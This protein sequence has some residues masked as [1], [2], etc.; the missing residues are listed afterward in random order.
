MEEA[1][2]AVLRRAGMPGADAFKNPDY[3]PDIPFLIRSTEWCRKGGRIAMTL[4]ARL[5]LKNKPIPVA[6]R[7]T[8]FRMMDIAGI[9]SGV[10]L[11]KTEVWPGTDQPYILLFA[12]NER[13]GEDPRTQLVCPHYESE[14]N[15]RGE[16]RIDA[17][18]SRIVNPLEAEVE[19]W[20]WKGWL[21]GSLLDV[22]VVRKLK[23]HEKALRV[24]VGTERTR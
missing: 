5:L 11:A 18:A 8:L 23:A 9:I 13:P 6:A 14:L 3:N 10:N 20:L 2:R 7:N 17:D 24:S 16:F 21:V 19:P 4:P 22:E 1:C 15:K 12:H